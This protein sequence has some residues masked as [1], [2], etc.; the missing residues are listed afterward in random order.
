MAFNLTRAAGALGGPELAR[1]TTGTIRRKLINV[2][3]RVATSARRLTLHLPK[4]WPWEHAW[5]RLFTSVSDPPLH[6]T[7]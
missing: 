3:A 1:A 6:Q 4:A 2:P 7:A 5:T